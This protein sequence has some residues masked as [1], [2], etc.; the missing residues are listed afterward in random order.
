MQ[1]FARVEITSGTK[2]L[3]TQYQTPQASTVCEL[4]LGSVRRECLDHFFI[5]Q[6]KQLHR[7]LNAHVLYLNH[8]RPLQGL[9]QQIPDPF[10]FLL[11]QQTRRTRFA[12]FRV[13]WVAS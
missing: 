5:F 7:L 13:R 11:L 9:E 2:V 8:A 4:F 12:P 1:Q 10:M 6:E 3:R